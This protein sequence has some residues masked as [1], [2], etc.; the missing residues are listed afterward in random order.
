MQSRNI[1]KLVDVPTLSSS[2]GSIAVIESHDIVPFPIERVYYLYGVP[3]GVERGAHAHKNL[4]QLIIAINSKFR[5][6]LDDGLGSKLTFELT[7][8]NQALMLPP[9]YWRDLSEFD[10]DSVCLVLA[11]SKYEEHDYM[12]DYDEFVRW[13]KWRTKE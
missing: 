6:H 12:R 8:P 11:S 9:G 13:A 7:R 10:E 1:P 5:I 4:W 2:L 3:K